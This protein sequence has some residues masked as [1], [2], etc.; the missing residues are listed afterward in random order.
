[1][2]L[3]ESE[4]KLIVGGFIFYT[5][6]EG[7]IS[8]G[9]IDED[10]TVHLLLPNCYIRFKSDRVG[11]NDLKKPIQEGMLWISPLLEKYVYQSNG[12]TITIDN[13]E[14]VW[15]DFQPEVLKVSFPKWLSDNFGFAL[16]DWGYQFIKDS[17]KLQIQLK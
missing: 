4:F 17:K 11:W 1:M 14:A 3:K 16:P 8:F 12:M 9:P 5:K 6:L 10:N 7:Y 15:V 2:K 13:F